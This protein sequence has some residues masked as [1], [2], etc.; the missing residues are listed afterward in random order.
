MAPRVRTYGGVRAELSAF[1][2]TPLSVQASTTTR[3]LPEQHATVGSRPCSSKAPAPS[4][5]KR[6]MASPVPSS[7]P[8]IERSSNTSSKGLRRSTRTSA[9]LARPM[10]STSTSGSKGPEETSDGTIEAASPST[11]PTATRQQLAPH[12]TF[13]QFSYVPAT[14]TTVVTTTTTTTTTFPPL[15]F[16]GLR[17]LSD[18]DPKLYPLAATPTPLSLKTISFDLNGVPAR[19][20]E[21][22]DASRALEDVSRSL[23][24]P[25]RRCWSVRTKGADFCG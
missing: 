23:W 19:F 11:Q 13:G 15:L 24:D 4:P 18:L 1:C 9:T 14:Q 10:M 16:E 8:K 22:E 3:D 7:R 21:A 2:L 20:T 12:A 6:E 25:T 5:S 17:D